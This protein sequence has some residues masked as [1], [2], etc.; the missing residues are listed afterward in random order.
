MS[1]NGLVVDGEGWFVVNAHA[2]RW[3]DEGPL[4]AYCTFEGKRRFPQLGVNI[5]VLEPGQRLG[6]L[7]R[8]AAV[9][10]GASVGRET[11]QSAVA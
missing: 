1:R 5:S 8:E 10:Y 9:R 3:R 7:H 11:T 2:S 6:M 4:G